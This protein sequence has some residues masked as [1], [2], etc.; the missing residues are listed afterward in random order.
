MIQQGQ[1]ELHKFLLDPSNRPAQGQLPSGWEP[2]RSTVSPLRDLALPAL[3][4]LTDHP[5]RLATSWF[6]SASFLLLQEPY[7]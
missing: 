1:Q 3:G 4:L 7:R 6:L 5:A 2:R